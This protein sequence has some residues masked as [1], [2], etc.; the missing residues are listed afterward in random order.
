MPTASAGRIV[1]RVDR[2]ADSKGKKY[3]RTRYR[4]IMPDP[5]APPSASI[6]LE[7]TFATRTEAA[8]WL[9]EQNTALDT[10]TYIAASK[11]QTPLREV[12][13]LWRQTW[14]IKPLA[15]RTQAGY[16]D[17]LRKHVEPRWADV[18]VCDITAAAVQEWVRELT[19]SGLRAE[20]I[21][22]VYGVLRYTMKVAAQ[23][24]LIVANPCTKD[25]I[26]LPSRK[27]E[28][29][30]RGPML[31][32]DA[33]ELRQLVDAP[34]LHGRW[35]LPVRIAGI[36]GLRAGEVWGLRRGDIDI[37]HSTIR[38]GYAIKDDGG[39]LFAG[40]TKT[41]E[42]RAIAIDAELRDELERA[43]SAPPV[44]AQE[45]YAA[46]VVG[47]SGPE[48]TYVHDPADPARLLFVGDRGRPVS[49]NNFRTRFYSPVV[50]SLWPAGHRL[51]RLRFHDLR[52]T[53]ASLM[54]GVSGNLAVVQKRLGH[55][56][57]QTTFDR[58]GHLAPGDDKTVAD[59]LGN[60][61]TAAESNVTELRPA[62]EVS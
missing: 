54:L 59:A 18:A 36:V 34:L 24:K 5:D 4:A 17:I 42:R 48:L 3:V 8:G 33:S 51:H 37:L 58:Y 52:H 9:R 43:L 50:K 10:G 15:R 21:H 41:Y 44:R 46:I 13:A 60:L 56:S 32:L 20:T 45:G 14:P 57:I 2:C 38:V 23:H 47:T 25:V 22:H 62:E 26:T 31:F 11:A 61:Y 35:R 7:R 53:A 30:Q 39:V 6:K 40:P 29:A 28:Q 16:A 12:V 1:K 27:V 19:A 49:H 55:E